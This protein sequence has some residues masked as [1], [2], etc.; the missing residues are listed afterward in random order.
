MNPVKNFLAAQLVV[1]LCWASPA[2]AE[3]IQH[4]DASVPDSVVL[5]GEQVQQW[6]DLSGNGNHAVANRGIVLYPSTPL[7]GGDVGLDCGFQR[8]PTF[9]I[10]A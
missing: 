1:Y 7:A 8:N 4:L 3:L 10:R 6:N 5:F 2:G 9:P